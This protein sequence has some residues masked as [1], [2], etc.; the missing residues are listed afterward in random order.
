MYQRTDLA[1][2]FVFFAEHRNLRSISAHLLFKSQS[3]GDILSLPWLPLLSFH[4]KEDWSQ[5]IPLFFPLA[6]E[7]S[8]W[9]WETWCHPFLRRLAW[10]PIEHGATPPLTS[11]QSLFCIPVLRSCADD[12]LWL[13]RF[14]SWP[15]LK[16]H[17]LSDSYLLLCDSLIGS[18]QVKGN[19]VYF[20]KIV[21]F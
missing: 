18:F 20:A 11:N 8:R 3:Y 15:N 17:C 19:L 14:L 10:M 5:K 1:A 12:C 13:P 21:H 4:W 6:V 2:C 16:I 9:R 7:Y